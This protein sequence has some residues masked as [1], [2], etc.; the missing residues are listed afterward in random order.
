MVKTIAQGVRTARKHHQ[1]FECYR[2]IAPKQSYG[3]Q[4]NIYDDRMYTLAWHLDCQECANQYRKI[5]GH[6]YEDE[7][8]PPLRDEWCESGEYDREVD[9]WRGEF[10]H[11]VARMELTDQLR[12]DTTND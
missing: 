2:M 3:F 8:F 9:W 11:V 7:G 6:T 10:P 1:C 12:K 4:T 5:T